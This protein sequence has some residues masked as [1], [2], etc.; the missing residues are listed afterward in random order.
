MCVV[1][2]LTGKLGYSHGFANH[3]I[4]IFFGDYPGLPFFSYVFLYLIINLKIWPSCS[5]S[6]NCIT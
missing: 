1:I 4:Y 6:L 3:N 5:W 2:Y